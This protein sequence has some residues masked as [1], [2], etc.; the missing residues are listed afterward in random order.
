MFFKGI[1]DS[2][3][4]QWKKDY[5]YV[6]KAISYYNGNY[7]LVLKNPQN[8]GRIKALVEMFPNAKFIFPHRNPYDVYRSTVHLYNTVLRSQMLQTFSDAEIEDTV[9]YLFRE[10]MR[11]YISQRRL[12]PEGN[13]VEIAFTDLDENPMKCVESIYSSLGLPE[14][15]LAEPKFKDY[16]DSVKTYQKN[17]FSELPPAIL[18][19]INTEWDFYFKEFGYE[20]IG[21]TSA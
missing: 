6:V 11:N 3:M 21:A 20:K 1:A 18:Q 4:K 10:M 5:L 14:F 15:A 16:L 17:R 13:L 7:P 2:E 9:I 19:R 12:V 8:T